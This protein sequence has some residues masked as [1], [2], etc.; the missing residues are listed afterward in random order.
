MSQF[1]SLGMD[2]INLAFD[3]AFT[4]LYGFFFA[5]LV[6]LVI[7]YFQKNENLKSAF[8][9]PAIFAVFTIFNPYI[10]LPIIQ[11]I[12]LT[13]RVRRLFWLLPVNL[14]IAYA[15][16]V[17][18]LSQKRKLQRVV[19]FLVLTAFICLCGENMFSHMTKSENIYKVSNETL[20]ISELLE[21]DADSSD[22]K[23][24]LYTDL[25]LLELREYD[26][27]IC[28]LIRRNDLIKWNPDVS[29][30]DTIQ[31]IVSGKNSRQILSLPIRYGITID[32]KLF[33]SQIEKA[34]ITYIIVSNTFDLDGYLTEMGYQAIGTT[35]RF[36]VYR[37][38]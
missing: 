18:L 4:G 34:D 36:S 29:D 25:E 20:A 2:F 24:C 11:S 12:G 38:S 21:E 27:S 5:Y 31:E 13:S 1:Y 22:E 14:L 30:P 15:F 28:N 35:E 37:T 10:M 8:V 19:V 6:I 17:L 16:T 3:N 33:Q 32:Q 23:N 9:Y 26:A 7:L